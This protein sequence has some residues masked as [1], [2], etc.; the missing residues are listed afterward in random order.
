MGVEIAIIATALAAAGTMSKL[1]AA[2]DQATAAIREGELKA[3]EAAK[4]I[5]AKAA[6]QKVSFLSSGFT[7]EG[8]PSSVLRSTYET[9]RQDIQQILS[10]YE[11]Q[12]GSIMSMA[13]AQALQEIAGME[14]GFSGG[15]GGITPT[16]TPTA[17]V[18]SA[19]PGY[20]SYVGTRAAI[21]RS[22][23]F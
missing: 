6:S 8:T 20:S 16:F 15:D 2:E 19:A 11:T 23:P 9:G 14:S 22:K 1:E 7:L 18:S 10:N 5:A 12:A 21:P 3:K 13:R 17:T 4:G